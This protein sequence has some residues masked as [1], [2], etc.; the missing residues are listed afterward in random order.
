M[1][2][3]INTNIFSSEFLDISTYITLFQTIYQSSVRGGVGR[4][5]DHH[6]TA[7]IEVNGRLGTQKRR[8]FRGQLKVSL[9]L[10]HELVSNPQVVVVVHT[11]QVLVYKVE[12]ISTKVVV[13]P[14]PL[15]MAA[16]ASGPIYLLPRLPTYLCGREKI[17]GYLFSRIYLAHSK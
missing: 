1:R 17:S 2:R 7:S 4:Q 6:H 11:Q 8:F 14:T 15:R 3:V 13:V 9:S 5:E 10:K 12:E 16:A